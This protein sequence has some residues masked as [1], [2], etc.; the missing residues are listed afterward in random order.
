MTWPLLACL[1]F[2]AGGCSSEPTWPSKIENDWI[3]NVQG[4]GMAN[5][6][7]VICDIADIGDEAVSINPQAN[8]GITAAETT[9]KNVLVFGPKKIIELETTGT[10]A[11]K[12]SIN[13]K[14]FGDVV[15]GNRVVIDTDGNVYVDQQLRKPN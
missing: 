7:G 12:L 9:G 6:W 15:V 11:I 13:G 8:L 1:I 14:N 2:V 4:K 3:K 10:Q 5:V